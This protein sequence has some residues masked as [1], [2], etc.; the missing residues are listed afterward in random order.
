MRDAIY[1]RNTTVLF[2]LGLTL[3]TGRVTYRACAALFP[4]GLQLADPV[5]VIRG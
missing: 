5:A 1:C 2:G 4:D 3:T